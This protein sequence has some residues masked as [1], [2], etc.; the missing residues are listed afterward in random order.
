MHFDYAKVKLKCYSEMGTGESISSQ[1][2]LH[3]DANILLYHGKSNILYKLAFVTTMV[4]NRQPQNAV[5]EKNYFH[6]SVSQL[7]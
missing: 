3:K 1:T 4:H 5:T 7:G 2:T 6:R